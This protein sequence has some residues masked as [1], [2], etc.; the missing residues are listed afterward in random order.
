M[1][2]VFQKGDYGQGAMLLYHANITWKGMYF[3]L[4]NVMLDVPKLLQ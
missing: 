4:W 1:T 3:S 2:K